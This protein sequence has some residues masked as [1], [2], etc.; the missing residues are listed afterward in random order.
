MGSKESGG[1]ADGR[2]LCPNGPYFPRNRRDQTAAG[3]AK[4]ERDNRRPFHRDEDY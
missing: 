2:A 3:E 1:P 4:P